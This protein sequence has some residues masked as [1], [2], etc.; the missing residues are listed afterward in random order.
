M[1]RAS[2]NE[3]ESSFPDIL[4]TEQ[5]NELDNDDLLNRQDDTE[6]DVIDRRFYEMNR[7]IGELTKLV[8]APTQQISSNT[9]KKNGLNAALTSANS[10]SDTTAT[11]TC[12][13][14][15]KLESL[16]VKPN[17]VVTLIKFKT[18]NQ[19]SNIALEIFSTLGNITQSFD[20]EY[21][22]I[23]IRSQISLEHFRS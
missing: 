12:F 13:K 22:C 7:Q 14:S 10:R 19:T 16:Q 5:M 20:S 1:E 18:R 9:R 4:S 21:Y 15:G 8:L 17:K 11:G 3:S 2:D 6:R 23:T